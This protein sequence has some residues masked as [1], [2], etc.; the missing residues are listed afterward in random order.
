MVEHTFALA[1][2]YIILKKVLETIYCNEKATVKHFYVFINDFK[3][4]FHLSANNHRIKGPLEIVKSSTLI[5]F[6]RVGY[7][8]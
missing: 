1:D 7:T 5:K 4:F 8:G 3:I 2:F 6:P